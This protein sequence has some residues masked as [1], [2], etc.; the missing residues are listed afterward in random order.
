MKNSKF[1]LIFSKKIDGP[2]LKEK[3]EEEI[4]DEQWIILLLLTCDSLFFIYID[5]FS[6]WIKLVFSVNRTRDLSY[7]KRKSCHRPKTLTKYSLFYSYNMLLSLQFDFKELPP[8]S[9]FLLQISVSFFLQ[10]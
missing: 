1:E 4:E 9:S 7:P 5:I 6:L 10:K 3:E 8:F 2:S